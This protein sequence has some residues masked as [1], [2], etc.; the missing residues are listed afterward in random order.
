MMDK[1]ANPPGLYIH[2]PFCLSKCPYC[3]FYSLTDLRL[4]PLWLKALEQEGELYKDEF[5]AFDTLYLG[6]GTPSLLS[7]SQLTAL[8]DSLRRYFT[9]A[10]DPEITLE[11]NPDDLTPEKLRLYLDL[12][13][14]RLS[15]GVQSFHEAELR[16]LGR[17]HTAR[18]ATVALERVRA[19]DF[20]NL[21]I[22]LIYGLPGQTPDTW[23]QN[24]TRA[25]EFAPEHLSC[26][27]LTLEEGTPWAA[28]KAQGFLRPPPEETER[29]L[30]LL[31]SE[32]LEERGY[33]H[34]EISNFAK[35][36]AHRSR[37][38]RK[39][40]QH[41]PYLGLGPGAHS[42]KEGVRWW[43]H[44]SLDDYS[45][46]LAHGLAPR[47]GSETLTPA[48]LRLEALYLGFRTREGVPLDLLYPQPGWEKI[49]AEL[50]QEG[51]VMVHNHRAV[52]TRQGFA[53]ADRLPLLFVE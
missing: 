6:G 15:V 3:D 40:W 38:N 11:A 46:A 30:F 32:F 44:R 26:Y 14:N 5:A 35:G 53:V 37:H 10:P 8:L 18:Q 2:I 25:L 52:P 36:A 7:A 33:L 20:A 34:Y 39:Y 27:Q 19:A 31:T 4:I 16:F 1:D 29:E 17:R 9:F 43:N 12:G 45:R 22:D 50:Q 41:L 47:A 51:L 21:S 42:F 28:L 24:L 23:E 48:Q 49:L 13:V